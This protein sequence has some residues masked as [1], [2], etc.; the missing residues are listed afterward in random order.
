MRIDTMLLKKIVEEC[1]EDIRSNKNPSEGK[2]R[3]NH[4]WAAL[5]N[6]RIRFVD[7]ELFLTWR[8]LS[9]ELA[10]IYNEWYEQK[11]TTDAFLRT[12]NPLMPMGRDSLYDDTIM[13]IYKHP[14][15]MGIFLVRMGPPATQKDF[16]TVF[17]ETDV[18]TGEELYY[19]QPVKNGRPIGPNV[20]I[21]NEEY[22][23]ICYSIR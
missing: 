19:K 3:F 5:A 4:I 14:D 1:F 18:V 23:A 9:A 11:F 2:I 22:E 15:C 21:T 17:Q 13:R 20:R 12:S 6:K 10:I 8:T 16:V 7:N